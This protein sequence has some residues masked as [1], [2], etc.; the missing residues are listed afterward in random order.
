MKSTLA[1][2]EELIN[3]NY[4][5]YD[6]MFQTIQRF[7]SQ[8]AT[9]RDQLGN[10][11]NE[12]TAPESDKAVK[13][14]TAAFV[15][16]RMEQAIQILKGGPEGRDKRW[17]MAMAYKGLKE[18]SKALAD[19]ERAKAKGWNEVEVQAQVVEIHRLNKDLKS[20]K[21]ELNHL[22][23]IAGDT[24]YY[25]Y[26]AAGL[27]EA[28][29]N[30]EQ[31]IDHLQQAVDRDPKYLPALF[32]LAFLLDL[33]GDEEQAVELYQQCL[34]F[35][36]IHINAAIN[37]SVLY[38]D[39]AKYDKA[40][41]L[42]ERVLM[43]YPNHPRARLFLRDVESSLYMFYDE[44]YER[45]RD[46]FQQVLDMPISDFELSVRSRNC[47]KKMGIKTLGD[48]TR[49]TEAELLSYK[50]FGETSLNEIKI[51]LTSKNLRLG[52]A[53]EDKASKKAAAMLPGSG[54]TTLLSADQA[55]LDKSIDELQL[56]VRSKKCLQ[57][58]NIATLGDLMQYS[59]P[60]LM[61]VK[62]FGS[63]SLTEVKEKLTGMG[64][65]L[66]ESEL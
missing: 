24:V 48:L 15:L 21:S 60:Q 35:N 22:K 33:N 4:E 39:A 17:L 58:L 36:P 20:A 61:S 11:V 25:F 31:A 16:G 37:L 2:V 6:E 28:D 23:K 34:T 55:I 29:G 53:V 45:K 5:N 63:V 27:A 50:N 3:G 41:Q 44:E 51:I 26:Q 46:K 12:Q 52:Q 59:E 49:I 65:S 57:K 9:D 40:E 66:R 18:Y 54:L 62:N 47:L 14:A 42:L 30:V 19:L 8:S 13:L 64:L 7:A 1:S 10:Y 32:R 38:E 43:V 56:S